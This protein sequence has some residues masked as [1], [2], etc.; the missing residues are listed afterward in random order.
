MGHLPLPRIPLFL[1]FHL[2]AADPQTEPVSHMYLRSRC[3]HVLLASSARSTDPLSS[4]NPLLFPNT[5]FL[6]LRP[7]LRASPGM[8]ISTRSLT[9][10]RAPYHTN[11]HW[12]RTTVCSASW[13]PRSPQ[14]DLVPPFFGLHSTL[15][16]PVSPHGLIDS[17]LALCLPSS[18]PQG[19]D[20]LRAGRGFI[21]L[22][23]VNSA[24]HC[25]CSEGLLMEL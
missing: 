14:S 24:W 17:M 19:D 21:N 6:S 22:C 13:S 12:C 1:L 16:L 2:Q 7:P 18:L 4:L 20:S 11:Q 8:E 15:F 23:F 25:R 10:S 5:P 9:G 3:P